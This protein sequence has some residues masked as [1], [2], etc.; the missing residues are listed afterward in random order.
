MGVQSSA[1]AMRGYK[2]LQQAARGCAQGGTAAV[3]VGA[4]GS[5][6]AEGGAQGDAAAGGGR[7]QGSVAVGMGVQGGA[8]AVGHGR[9]TDTL[10][11][12]FGTFWGR[13]KAKD[14]DFSQEL[15]RRR[16]ILGQGGQGLWLHPGQ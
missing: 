11:Q 13:S 4:Q 5:A 12:E 8:A 14:H 1:A 15:R 10:S 3:G 6:A 9:G 16:G 2:V 7:A